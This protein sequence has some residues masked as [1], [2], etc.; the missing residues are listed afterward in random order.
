MGWLCQHCRFSALNAHAEGGEMRPM[1]RLR[2]V[3][4]MC[5]AAAL[6]VTSVGGRLATASEADGRFIVIYL[7]GVSLDLEKTLLTTLG[8]EVTHI[9]SLINA[10][11]IKIPLDLVGSILQF[12]L[13]DPSV[14]GVYDDPLGAAAA[15]TPITWTSPDGSG[16]E[17][18]DWG[19]ERIGAP[20]A[21]HYETGAGVTVTVLDT[22]ID[23]DHPEL[24]ERIVACLNAIPGGTSCDDDNGHGTHI[25]GIIAAAVNQQGMIGAAPQ[26]KLAAVKVLDQN[27]QGRASDVIYGLQW[28]RNKGY[29]LVNM[30]LGFRDE[31]EPLKRAVKRLYDKKVIMVAAA[32]NCNSGDGGGEEGDGDGGSVGETPAGCTTPQT[33]VMYPAGYPWTIAVAAT[34]YYNQVAGYSQAGPQVDVA[35]PGGSIASGIRIFSTMRGGAYAL[36]S[37]TSQAAAHVSGAVALAL[38]RQPSLSFEQVLGLLQTTAWDL[39]YP[40]E[41]QGAGLIDVQRMVEAL[42]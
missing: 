24:S 40:P 27:A 16:K 38:Q 18:F 32:G 33:G 3:V 25:A 6:I 20:D 34:D 37:G 35:A 11:S 30:S 2:A 41:R 14:V 22:G 42:P 9:L 13:S 26:A 29:R 19:M 39:G 17:G 21:Q 4:C 5:M 12:L 15:L 36:G 7:D 31:N 28:V 23:L 8:V 10:L 1:A